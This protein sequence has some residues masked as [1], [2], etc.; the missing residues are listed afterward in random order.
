MAEGH[1]ES[2]IDGNGYPAKKD[3]VVKMLKN[4]GAPSWMIDNIEKMSV[5]QF[6]DFADV[7]RKYNE[8][9]PTE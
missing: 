8:F 3:D 5:I 7:S 9:N 4:N 6:D 2:Y 1:I